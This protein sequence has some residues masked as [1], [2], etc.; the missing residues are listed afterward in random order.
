MKGIKINTIDVSIWC[1]NALL[2]RAR[3]VNIQSLISCLLHPS[4]L[5]MTSWVCPEA[6]SLH[7]MV[8]YIPCF[9]LQT[10]NEVD[11][12]C[13]LFSRSCS[14]KLVFLMLKVIVVVVQGSRR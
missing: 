8:T 2:S 9:E 4:V 12:C 14:L 13:L 3:Y 10:E 5:M 1:Y 6:I 7:A 11:L